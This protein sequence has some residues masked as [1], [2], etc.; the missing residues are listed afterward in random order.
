MTVEPL[1]ITE[2]LAPGRLSMDL[3]TQEV[4]LKRI[5]T[6]PRAQV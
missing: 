2:S 1:F 3:S 6:P 4:F 5:I